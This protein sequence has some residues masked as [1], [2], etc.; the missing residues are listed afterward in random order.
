M[1]GEDGGAVCG[2]LSFSTADGLFHFTDRHLSQPVA[3]RLVLRQVIDA[4]GRSMLHAALRCRMALQVKDR[5][6]V[7]RPE[8]DLCVTCRHD[9]S[10]QRLHTPMTRCTLAGN[11]IGSRFFFYDDDETKGVV[12]NTVAETIGTAASGWV[13]TVAVIKKKK[14]EFVRHSRQKKRSSTGTGA[15]QAEE[16]EALSSTV[17]G[18]GMCGS[19]SFTDGGHRGSP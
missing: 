7:V 3:F 4:H 14:K 5:G 6:L 12:D 11:H 2:M 10:H 19:A 16:A 8:D 15:A 13:T 9:R 17:E 1:L 18:C